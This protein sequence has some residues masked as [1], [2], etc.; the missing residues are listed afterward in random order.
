MRNKFGL[1]K[2][3]N[4]IAAIWH[5]W[6]TSKQY[7]DIC[8]WSLERSAGMSK[9]N[10]TIYNTRLLRNLTCRCYY[11]CMICLNSSI[12]HIYTQREKIDQISHIW[13]FS[14]WQ[15]KPT[16]LI[17]ISGR[18][19]LSVKKWWSYDLH[20]CATFHICIQHPTIQYEQ[21]CQLRIL[22]NSGLFKLLYI[23]GL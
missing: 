6:M 13:M 16:V 21:C 2:F 14:F 5:H 18:G 8:L 1:L 10:I 15:I 19:K 22:E 9:L 17:G 11:L 23:A 7:S 4:T 12:T 20:L 3:H